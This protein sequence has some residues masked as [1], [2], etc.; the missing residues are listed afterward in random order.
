MYS[1]FKLFIYRQGKL[2]LRKDKPEEKHANTK[3]FFLLSKFIYS[4]KFS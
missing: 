2:N 4:F 3:D 1:Y